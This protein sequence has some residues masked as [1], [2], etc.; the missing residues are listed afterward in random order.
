[1]KSIAAL[2]FIA[3]LVVIGAVISG[4]VGT[5]HHSAFATAPSARSTISGPARVIDSDTIVVSGIHIRLQGLDGPERGNPVGEHARAI[6]IDIVAD[7]IITCQP[8]GTGSYNRVVATC[9]LPD[10]TDISRELVRRGWGLDCARYSHGRYRKDEPTGV[11]QKL[12][13]AR[14]C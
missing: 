3:A 12:S 7:Q 2:S 14:Y 4:A 5:Q 10:G 1:M 11:R 8:D 6:M 9:L 13:Q